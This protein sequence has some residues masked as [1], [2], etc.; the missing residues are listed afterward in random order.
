M[1]SRRD[2]SLPRGILGSVIDQVLR[3]TPVPIMVAHPEMAAGP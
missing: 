2:A 3:E 1:L